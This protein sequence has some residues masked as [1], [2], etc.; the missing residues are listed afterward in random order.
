M[1]PYLP[2][3]SETLRY[4]V[5]AA[6]LRSGTECIEHPDGSMTL[7][8]SAA[9][10]MGGKCSFASALITPL[11]EAV[12]RFSIAYI[13]RISLSPHLEKVHLVTTCRDERY[14]FVNAFYNMKET[15]ERLST[16]GVHFVVVPYD[17]NRVVRG[18]AQIFNPSQ[19]KVEAISPESPIFVIQVFGNLNI[20]EVGLFRFILSSI[21]VNPIYEDHDPEEMGEIAEYRE[22]GQTLV[23]ECRIVHTYADT[24]KRMKFA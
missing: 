14:E 23:P 24:Y 12:N 21:A 10:I 15:L 1:A 18:E 7:K 22:L 17:R 16:E 8:T 11:R 3:L 20:E 4:L 6:I 9:N 19:E 13:K 2:Q 5:H